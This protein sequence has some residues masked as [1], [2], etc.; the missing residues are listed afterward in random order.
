MDGDFYGRS[1]KQS[2]SRGA[3]EFPLG[4]SRN[5]P[6]PRYAYGTGQTMPSCAATHRTK[7][8]QRKYSL[9]CLNDL[10]RHLSL[11]HCISCCLLHLQQYEFIGGS[12][13]GWPVGHSFA[14]VSRRRVN[15]NR[16]LRELGRR[17]CPEMA[18]RMCVLLG[19]LL[20][21]FLSVAAA[22]PTS[23]PTKGVGVMPPS[24]IIVSLSSSV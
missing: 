14:K 22:T 12:A 1:T 16:R 11:R 19:A 6:H 13:S 17:G 21:Q 2:P 4:S 23:M 24:S 8:T 20:T 7:A 5:P 15:S 18:T 10:C 3:A 9:S